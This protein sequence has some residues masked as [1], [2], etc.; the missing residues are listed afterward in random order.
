MDA[1]IGVLYAHTHE[2]YMHRTALER[3]KRNYFS[4]RLEMQ[5]GSWGIDMERE[6]TLFSIDAL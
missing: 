3:H 2:L 5:M 1:I 6:M 4:F